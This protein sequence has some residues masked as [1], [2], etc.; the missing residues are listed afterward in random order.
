MAKGNALSYNS[1]IKKTKEKNRKVSNSKSKGRNESKGSNDNDAWGKG[2]GKKLYTMDDD[3]NDDN[4]DDD[5]RKGND[6]HDDDDDEDGNGN[7][8][9][10]GFASMMSKI[11][12]Q[13]VSEGSQAVP[14]LA[15][16]K[17]A[18]MKDIE[19]GIEDKIKVKK[20]RIEKNGT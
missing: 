10:D 6:L 20:L 11:L 9:V 16:R 18:I 8:G 3:S 17:T 7:D 2:K 5:D 13:N 12:T 4:D 14:I 15:K 19:K 1:S